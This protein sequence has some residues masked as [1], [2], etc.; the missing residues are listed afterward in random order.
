M[1]FMM[2]VDLADAAWMK[3]AKQKMMAVFEKKVGSDMNQNAEF[4]VEQSMMKWM[5]E[6]EWMKNKSAT[7]E[8]FSKMMAEKMA[9][10][11]KM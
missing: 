5:N 11:K 7:M 1:M 10:K 4:F 9:A 6:A 2:M 3:L 8:T